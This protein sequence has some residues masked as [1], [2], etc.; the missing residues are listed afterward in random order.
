MRKTIN[1]N[2]KDHRFPYLS[3][4]KKSLTVCFIIIYRSWKK[5]WIQIGDEKKWEFNKQKPLG[6]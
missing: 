6:V 2:I 5:I 1:K 4:Y 3:G